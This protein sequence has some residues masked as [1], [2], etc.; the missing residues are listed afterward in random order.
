MQLETQRQGPTVSAAAA[1]CLSG[2]VSMCDWISV[3]V[4]MRHCRSISCEFPK[5]HIPCLLSTGALGNR[6]SSAKVR[7]AA[8]SQI[9]LLHMAAEGVWVCGRMFAV[10]KEC[11]CGLVCVCVFVVFRTPGLHTV[12]VTCW[13]FR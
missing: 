12:G 10:L 7:A 8:H 6:D 3:C 1:V 4:C 5:F 13:L 9:P 2:K 11:C